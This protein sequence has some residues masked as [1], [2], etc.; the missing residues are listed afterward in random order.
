MSYEITSGYS[1]VKISIWF[2]KSY[3]KSDLLISQFEENILN[4]S[5]SL[6]HVWYY[7]YIGNYKLMFYKYHYKNMILAHILDNNIHVVN[8]ISGYHIINV[9]WGFSVHS[10]K[11]LGPPNKK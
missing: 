5:R 2:T 3:L 10:C 6:I 8:Q 11:L 4:F 7:I 1:P 9:I